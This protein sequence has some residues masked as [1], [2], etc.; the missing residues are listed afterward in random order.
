MVEAGGRVGVGSSIGIAPGHYLYKSE[1]GLALRAQPGFRFV[2]APMPPA[3]TKDDPY[4]RKQVEIYEGA[5]ILRGEIIVAEDVKPREYALEF[6]TRYQGCSKETC[7]LPD[8]K[9]DKV[10]LKVVARASGSAATQV[11]PPSPGIKGRFQAAV[12]QGRIFYALLLCFVS[13]VLVSLTPCIYP[14]IP[15]T[16]GVIGASSLGRR[17]R[18]F[19]LSVAYVLGISITY[20]LLGVI[21]ASAGRLFGEFVQSVWI[22]GFVTIVF[23]ALSLSMFGLYELPMFSGLSERYQGRTGAGYAGVFVMGLIAGLVA[24]PCVGPVLASLLVYISTTRS[25]IKGFVM[26][27]V[28][29]WGMGVLLIVL[30]TFSSA[31]S[32]L[33]KSGQW[34]ILVKNVLGLLMLGAAFYYLET[35]VSWPVFLAALGVALLL[36][37]V[38][39]GGLDALTAEAGALARL[40][41][42]FGLLCLIAGVCVVAAVVLPLVGINLGSVSGPAV[43]QGEQVSES[44]A[45]GIPWLP[46]AQ[47]GLAKAKAEGK[48]VMM[49][50]WMLRCPE[51]VHLDRTTLVDPDVVKEAQRFVAIKV[52]CTYA[53][54]AEVSQLKARYKI[55]GAPTIIFLDS[56]GQWLED[57][58]VNGYIVASE[59]LA[60]MRSVQ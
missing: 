11:S 49:D 38:F 23:F 4:L 34:M 46:S 57:K 58:T 60:R 45:Q 14:L 30:G 20:A 16:V 8:S 56:K 7:F 52:D 22:S 27:F 9:I 54:S 35:I 21:A 39:S 15:I 53:S 17:G 1:T 48:P 31:V 2:P 44:S 6:E 55:V 3:L 37:S 13:G 24:S 33:P 43:E 26:M 25:V 42:T 50:F 41:K 12:Q 10:A 59:L 19:L 36:L 32:L 51:C 28:M 5:V 40:Q 47:E 29:A 18:G